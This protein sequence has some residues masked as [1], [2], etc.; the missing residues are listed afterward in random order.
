MNESVGLAMGRLV[1]AATFEDGCRIS[2][3]ISVVNLTEEELKEQR[4]MSLYRVLY[5]PQRSLVHIFDTPPSF[6]Q[7]TGPAED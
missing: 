1:K 6:D 2:I 4:A 3:S 7:H 5:L